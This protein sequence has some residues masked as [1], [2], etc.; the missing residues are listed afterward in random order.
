MH[1]LLIAL[2]TPCT[3][4]PLGP[5]SQASLS[6]ILH[7]PELVV[8]P[9]AVVHLVTDVVASPP[10]KRDIVV[11]TNLGLSTTLQTSLD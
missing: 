6:L 7:H 3:S 4:N 2:L 5:L 11:M 9:Q 8:L 10:T 1:L